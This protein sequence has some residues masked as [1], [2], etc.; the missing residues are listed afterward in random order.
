MAVYSFFF[1]CIMGHQRIQVSPEDGLIADLY[2]G[3]SL[4]L[5]FFFYMG[6]LKVLLTC[7]DIA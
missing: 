2:Y 7:Y 1:A 3:L 5:K 6:L 4:V